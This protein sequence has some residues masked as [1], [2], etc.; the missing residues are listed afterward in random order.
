[1]SD[2]GGVETTALRPLTADVPTPRGLPA[3]TWTSLCS[4]TPP[5]V[6]ETL[7]SGL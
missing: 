6:I 4:R 3:V 1:M 5:E 2:V 7:L